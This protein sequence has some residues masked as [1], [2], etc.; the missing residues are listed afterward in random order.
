MIGHEYEET[1]EGVIAFSPGLSIYIDN[2]D[3]TVTAAEFSLPVFIAAGDFE[4]YEPKQIID[5]IKSETI[6]TYFRDD[7]YEHGSELL[8][9]ESSQPQAYWDE[10]V[11][12]LNLIKTPN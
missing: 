7:A 4:S 8:W 5:S 3:L 6:V 2:Q 10:V 11:N 12:F 9:A 1:L